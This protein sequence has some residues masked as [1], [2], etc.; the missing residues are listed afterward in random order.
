M[1]LTKSILG[2]FDPDYIGEFIVG[3]RDMHPIINLLYDRANPQQM[4][5]AY[6]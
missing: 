4:K 5:N 3:W 1:T 2:E 6:A